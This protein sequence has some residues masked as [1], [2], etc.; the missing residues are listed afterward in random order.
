MLNLTFGGTIPPSGT[1]I[2][3]VFIGGGLAS[4]FTYH[5]VTSTTVPGPA[6]ELDT[7]FQFIEFNIRSDIQ[8]NVRG[9]AGALATANI[10]CV[11]GSIP[12]ANM[13]F[14][15]NPNITSSGTAQLGGGELTVNG[16]DSASDMTFATGYVGTGYLADSVFVTFTYSMLMQGW[17]S[18]PGVLNGSAI[19]MGGV[20]GQPPLEFYE[21]VCKRSNAGMW[22]NVG[23][24]DQPSVTYDTVFHI[25]QS[26]VKKLALEVSNETWNT[27]ASQWGAC[28]AMASAL[29]F[30]Q[31]YQSLTALK[32]L[33]MAAQAIAAWTAAGRDRSDLKIINAYWFIASSASGSGLQIYQFEGA[34]LN[35]SGSGSNVTFKAFGGPGATAIT[36]N[37][38]QYPNRPIDWCD[39]VGPAPYW[40]G[41]QYNSGNGGNDIDTSVPLSAYNGSL[42]AAYNYAYGTTA[43]KQAALDFL[44]NT[45]TG[46]G[47]LYNGTLNGGAPN[48]GE[49]IAPWALGSGFSSAGYFGIGTLLATYD[50]ARAGGTGGGAQARCG[51][52]C[53]EGGWIMGPIQNTGSPAS[54]GNDLANLGYGT[55]YSSSLGGA[56]TQPGAP[57]GAADTAALAGNNLALLLNDWKYDARCFAL[58]SKFYSQFK[59]AVQVDGVRDAFPAQYGWEGAQDWGAYPLSISESAPTQ[60]IAAMAAFQ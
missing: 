43:Q 23:L 15:F 59:A 7:T 50:T 34:E 19:N 3:L 25:A 26:G 32:I 18:T 24:I 47:D 58:V 28:Q 55:G 16:S 56:T 48:T 17:I 1:T 49:S 46:D 42:L 27:G 36:T 38:S 45:T 41:G 60:V 35:A 53:Y 57:T 13:T 37:Y 33:Q 22:Y 20:R 2:S 51:V 5:Y 31:G 54:V 11:N 44:Y 14:M 21:E 12:G 10:I 52:M 39:N 6:G 29:G 8:G 4:P 30:T 9:N 40:G